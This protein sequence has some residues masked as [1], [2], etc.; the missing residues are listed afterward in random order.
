MIADAVVRE[1]AP[2]SEWRTTEKK[3]VPMLPRPFVET[4][5]GLAQHS[6][7]RLRR[8]HVQR[9]GSVRRISNEQLHSTALTRD[10]TGDIWTRLNKDAYRG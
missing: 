8:E 4:D 1:P 2:G 6:G 9:D 10:A 5:Q 7:D 3:A